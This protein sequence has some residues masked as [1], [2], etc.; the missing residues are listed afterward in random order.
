M[1]VPL[2]VKESFATAL[3]LRVSTRPVEPLRSLPSLIVLCALL[4]L[5]VLAFGAVE[6]WAISMLEISAALLFLATVVRTVGF[7]ADRVKWNPLYAPMAGFA[8]VAAIQLVLNLTAYRY[9]TLLVSLEYCAYGMLAFAATQIAGGER[10]SRVLVLI[11]GIFGSAVALFAICQNLTSS[12]RIYWLRMP[13][14]DASIFG[15]YVNHD[16]YAGLMEMLTPL[17]LVLSLSTL[18]RGGQRIIA[19]FA[20]VLMAGSIVLSLS[21]GGAISLIAE[22]LLLS[23]MVFRTQKGAPALSRMVMLLGAMLAFLGLVG[24]PV[25]WRHLGHL[26][27]TL[28]LDI[29]R[30]SLR[31]FVRKPVLGWGLGTFQNVY[32]GFRSFYS[33]FFINAAHNDYVQ[34]LV[35][36]GLAG[37]ACAVWFIITLYRNGLRRFGSAEQ[38]WQDVLRV[39]TLVGCTGILVHSLYDF[40]LQVPGNAALFYVFSAFAAGSRKTGRRIGGRPDPV[41]QPGGVRLMGPYYD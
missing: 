26:Q 14:T 1:S 21:R 36:T 33:Q 6:T 38:N 4:M 41:L 24:S 10:S 35:E 5:G 17:A 37:F 39:A 2:R 28:R 31:M 3:R 32:P 8:A 25:M 20:A 13:T 9:E 27:D 16:H 22:L 34:V 29:L 7:S 12:L 15:P 23:F 40:N 18:V 11:F 30:D 19:A